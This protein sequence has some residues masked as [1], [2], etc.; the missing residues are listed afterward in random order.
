MASDPLVVADAP[1]EPIAQQFRIEPN[2][3]LER[4]ANHSARVEMGPTRKSVPFVRELNAFD[5]HDLIVTSGSPHVLGAAF[6][7][8]YV[9][10]DYRGVNAWREWQLCRVYFKRCSGGVKC[11]FLLGT[12]RDKG[13]RPVANCSFFHSDEELRAALLHVEQKQLSVTNRLSA[14]HSD[15]GASAVTTV[16]AVLAGRNTWRGYQDHLFYRSRLSDFVEKASTALAAPCGLTNSHLQRLIIS[17]CV[18][19]EVLNLPR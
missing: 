12:G 5:E 11:P 14:T 8:K 6:L 18:A 7:W 15:G 19:F 2:A 16:R 17:Y 9:K 4:I 10:I 3:P 1:V 13:G